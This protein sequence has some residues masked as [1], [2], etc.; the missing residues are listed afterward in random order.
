MF[1]KQMQNESFDVPGTK[2]RNR[3]EC[4]FCFLFVGNDLQK[5]LIPFT[6]LFE[7]ADNTQR[8]KL[9]FTYCM[10][11]VRHVVDGFVLWETSARRAGFTD[12]GGLDTPRTASVA[13]CT[14]CK[15]KGCRFKYGYLLGP[16]DCKA[17]AANITPNACR[18]SVS[19]KPDRLGKP[20]LA[21]RPLQSTGP[22]R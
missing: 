19:D 16:V 13:G 12:F 2:Y 14:N 8:V 11:V 1:L 9:Y 20:I 22:S 5:S 21:A 10:Y 15:T 17:C 6:T 18:A 4:V 3:I 7:V